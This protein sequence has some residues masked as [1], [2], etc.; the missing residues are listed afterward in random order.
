MLHHYKTGL[1]RKECL[2]HEAQLKS[3]NEK[4]INGKD[5]LTLAELPSADI[6]K[7]LQLAQEIKAKLQA[8]EKYEP[9]KG[10]H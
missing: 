4:I 5:F 2:K 7:L 1:K 10:K 6:A 8:G 9:L 3:R